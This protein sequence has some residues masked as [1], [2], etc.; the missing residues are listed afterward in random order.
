M[1]EMP[2]VNSCVSVSTADRITSASIAMLPS[3]ERA[4]GS[5]WKMISKKASRSAGVYKRYAAQRDNY[6]RTVKLFQT[7][8]YNAERVAESPIM[9]VFSPLELPKSLG[10]CRLALYCCLTVAVLISRGN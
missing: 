2:L 10:A 1:V 8:Y 9:F 4:Y 6:M 7:E 5:F 3:S